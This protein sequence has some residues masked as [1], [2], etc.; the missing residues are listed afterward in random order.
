MAPHGINFVDENQARRALAALFKHVANPARAHS[1]KHLHKIRSGDTE[2]RHIGLTGDRLGQQ[3]LARAGRADHQ[4]SLGN[5]PAHFGEFLGI[6]EELHDLGDFFLGLIATG[7]LGKRDLVT[8]PRKQFGATLAKTHGTA[9]R[10]LELPH[11]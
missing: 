4:N 3:G 11:K 5:L 8:V 10:L 1:D 9:P 6:F 2:K 7:D